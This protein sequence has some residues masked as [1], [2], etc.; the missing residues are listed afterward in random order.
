LENDLPFTAFSLIV[1]AALAHSTWNLLAKRAAHGR[2]LIFFSSVMESILFLPAAAWVLSTSRLAAGWIAMAFLLTTGV[3]HFLYTETLLRGYRSADLS[4]VYPL[5]RGTGP[6]L[7][8]FGAV[9][10]LG[11]HPSKLA[12]TGALL[13]TCGVLVLAGGTTAFR[14][15]TGRHGLW[16]GVA[17]GCTIACYTLV[18]G[19]SVKTLLLSPLL[20]EYAGNLFR[21]ILLLSQAYRRRGS[22]LVEYRQSWKAALGIAVLTP[23]GYI[24]VLFAMKIAPVSRVAPM[25]E[26]SMMIGAYF[27]ARFLNEGNLARRVSGSAIIAAGVAALALG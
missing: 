20:V 22:I 1:L 14:R 15:Q 9:L 27:G 4:V 8:F 11:E 6:L 7:S 3:L 19:Y 18:D 24:L 2:H 23:A 13:V 16:W 12:T 10:L 21:T 17:T 5:A 26:M 25:R